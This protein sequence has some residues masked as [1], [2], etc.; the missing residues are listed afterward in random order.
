MEHP[1]RFGGGCYGNQPGAH[2]HATIAAHVYGGGVQG[3][4]AALVRGLVFF[5]GN[6][7]LVGEFGYHA[8]RVDGEGVRGLDAHVVRLAGGFA[9]ALHLAD[10]GAGDGDF[11]HGWF[12]D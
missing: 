11:D 9:D 12:L 7:E 1:S 2:F 5:E 4:M 8:V 10:I 6:L 3:V